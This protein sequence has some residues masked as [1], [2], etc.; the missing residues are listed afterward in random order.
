[1]NMRRDGKPELTA[2]KLTTGV[3][4]FWTPMVGQF[5]MPVDMT[6]DRSMITSTQPPSK[7]N[8]MTV[9]MTDDQK[10]ERIHAILD[11]VIDVYFRS[12]EIPFENAYALAVLAR[13]FLENL[14]SGRDS[15]LCESYNSHP[16]HVPILFPSD[17]VIG[18]HIAGLAGLQKMLASSWADRDETIIFV[19]NEGEGSR[20]KAPHLRLLP[21]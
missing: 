12:A 8:A 13:A 20:I 6:G 19:G 3:G 16:D 21:S 2:L 11:V 1:M 4:Q 9:T 5:S 15:E 17:G 14:R 18:E 7:E 10:L